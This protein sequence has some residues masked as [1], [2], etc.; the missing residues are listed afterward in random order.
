MDIG[1]SPPRVV[2]LSL[3]GL[4]L[5]G[6]I[7]P[8]LGELTRLTALR[9]DGNGLRGGVP[10][11]LGQLAHLELLWLKNNSLAGALPAALG[12]LPKLSAVRL[13]GNELDGPVPAPLF[14]LD[15]DLHETLF[16]L[17]S[18]ATDP[19]LLQDCNALLAGRDTLAGSARL[20][21]RRGLPIGLWQGVELGGAPPRVT[22]LDVAAL[23]LSGE[24]PPELGQLAQLRRL[25]LGGN[26]LTGTVPVALGRLA[27]LETLRLF[28]AADSSPGIAAGGATP[29]GGGRD[30]HGAA[31]TVTDFAR[32][33]PCAPDNP[34]LAA[35]CRVLLAMRDTLAGSGV[36]NWDLALPVERW[37]GVRLA[38]SP[39]RVAQLRLAA[40][41]LNGRVPA[42][43]AQLDQLETVSLRH[44][45]LTGGIP[46]ELGRLAKLKVLSLRDNQLTGPIPPALGRLHALERLLLNQNNLTGAIPQALA[47]LPRLTTIL[48]EKNALGGCAPP[49]GLL[50]VESHDL[51]PD[52]FHCL[53]LGAHKAGLAHDAAILLAARDQIAGEG[54]LNWSAAISV[55]DWQ[56]VTLAQE[57]ASGIV[58][59]DLRNA[60]LTGQ[61]PRQFGNLASLESL[62]LNGN[63][64]SGP[65]PPEIAQLANL[66]ELGLEDN[67]L[68]GVVP[69]ALGMRPGQL[70]AQLAGNQFTGPEPAAQPGA[71]HPAVPA[72][73]LCRPQAPIDTELVLDCRLLLAVRDALA[74][75]GT[76]NWLESMPLASWRGVRIAGDPAR[77]V[78][79]ELP[80]AGLAGQIPPRLAELPALR[81]LVL[82]GN[83]LTGP[84]P[85]ALADLTQLV[86]LNLEGNALTG[87]VPPALAAAADP[88]RRQPGRP[89]AANPGQ[90]ASAGRHRNAFAAPFPAALRTVADHDLPPECPT[91]R[92]ANPGLVQD[93]AHLL[94]SRDALAGT[95][96]LNWSERT[97][98]A[99]WQ[100]V[101][102][103]GRPLRVTAVEL[104]EARLTG[105]LPAA[106]GRLDRLER[107]QL[108]GN[109]L[110]GPIPPELGALTRLTHLA[111]AR[112]RLSGPIPRELG[113]LPR[114]AHLTLAGNDLDTSSADALRAVEHHDLDIEVFCPVARAQA[115]ALFDDCQTLLALRDPLAGRGVLNWRGAAP[116]GAWTGVRLGGDPLRVVALELAGTGIDGRIPAE[117]ANLGALQKLELSGNALRG[118][119]PAALARLPRLKTLRLADNRLSG[120]LP[121]AL[122]ALDLDVLRLAG[123]TFTRPLPAFP[124]GV[125]T[126]MAGAPRCAGLPPGNRGLADDCAE[127]LSLQDE[128]AGSAQLNW[129]AEAPIEGWDGVQ[130]GGIPR[131]VTGLSLGGEW[132]LDGRLPASLGRLPRLELIYLADNALTGPIPAE[133]GA[134][135][136]LK[137]LDIRLNQLSGAIPPELSRLGRLQEMYLSRNRLTGHVPATLAEMTDLA[138]FRLKGNLF[139]DCAAPEALASAV[140]DRDLDHDL[141]H[142]FLCLPM[143]RL[144][145]LARDAAALLQARDA[146]AGAGALDWRDDAPLPAWEGVTLSRGRHPR[147]Q[148]LDLSGKMLTGNIPASI[149]DLD[150]LRTLHLHGNALRGAVPQ[151]LGR[152]RH[153]ES[154]RLDGNRLDGTLPPALGGLKSLKLLRL[155]GNEFTGVAPVAL[156]Q[157]A[158][159]DL[160]LGP[161]CRPGTGGTTP[162]L[163]RDCA[164]LLAV[165]DALAGTVAL[166]WHPRAPIDFWRG[167]SLGGAPARVVAL[168]LTNLGLT[169]S[170]PPELGDLDALLALRL[171]RNALTGA[172]PGAL[173]GLA[174]LQELALGGNLLT[175]SIPPELGRLA[176][177]TTLRL[178]N[179]GLEG[180]IPAALGRLPRLRELALDGNALTGAMPP[181][182][183]ES[184]A[185]EELW[186][187]GNAL[188]GAGA[189]ATP[190]LARALWDDPPAP[191]PPARALRG[192]P[193]A[194]QVDAAG[195]PDALAQGDGTTPPEAPLF[196]TREGTG[197]PELLHDCKRLVLTLEDLTDPTAL[198]WRPD[199][200]LAQWQ[201]VRLGGEPLRVTGIDVSGMGVEGPLSGYFAELPA[202][203]TWRMADNALTGSIPPRIGR[204]SALRV[205]SLERNNLTGVLPTSFENLD[206]L[207][208]LRLND[209]ALTGH[210]VGKLA[211]LPNLSSMRLGGNDFLGC[212]PERL[213]GIGDRRLELDLDCGPTPWSKPGLVED[214]AALMASREGLA[215]GA[216]LNWLYDN[217]ISAWQGVTVDGSPPRVVALDLAFMGLAGHIPRELGSLTALARLDLTGNQLTGG[218]PAELGRL[219]KLHT[220][221]LTANRLSGELPEALDHLERI[222]K[223]GIH[224]NDIVG[225]PP[226]ML[227]W[228]ARSELLSLS[229]AHCPATWHYQTGG[230]MGG[231]LLSVNSMVDPG[232][233]MHLAQGA[234]NLFLQMGL[235]TGLLGVGALGL[236]CMSLVLNLRSRRGRAVTPV[237]ALA[238]AGV[239]MAIIHSAFDIFLLQYMMS[240]AV[241]VWMFLGLGTGLAQQR[242]EPD[243]DRAPDA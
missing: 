99:V 80:A 46:P 219:A 154:L 192:D 135:T 59:L 131:R 189:G 173:G 19:G 100:G 68:S 43:L 164:I 203:E 165:R 124:A 6:R 229:L 7:P 190:T 25:A 225:C 29:G 137:R 120:A 8:V 56:G 69:P 126:D 44:N 41:G 163:Q 221:L 123:N 198:N 95:A 210:L 204:L 81:R 89:P 24:I 205:L 45:A 37:E 52:I 239:A 48:L 226:V 101:A 116:L 132:G 111:L 232:R 71:A 96:V 218:V 169:G 208:E 194:P 27:E 215:G 181:G 73:A 168:D 122:A 146:L 207:A 140:A 84:I 172:I 171:G 178:R 5:N 110:A 64:L 139:L 142:T 18:A 75:G 155:A 212:M 133:L 220:L 234:H 50:D 98:M 34:G 183:G 170:I 138:K 237:Q 66:R 166:N 1:G 162:S 216:E 152:L 114:L 35:D 33:P 60:G 49:P 211:P 174:H 92:R 2:A 233:E 117:L 145:D 228:R 193:P 121:A 222:A 74:G 58:A 83:A 36:L 147:V 130:I 128:L 188:A 9:L 93:C 129:S 42:A 149:G 151:E 113:A 63:Q 196:C 160:G 53:P 180:R 224:G 85:A 106:L 230:W 148:G 238:A 11:E 16:C 40:Q 195:A 231:T 214:A 200:P 118:E 150:A 242:A 141:D 28:L 10:A 227:G 159:H 199:V 47:D 26:A 107:L 78:A 39:P 187:A 191:P 22:G 17:P 103:E 62:R 72:G 30:A 213:R 176:N 76:L 119:V 240:V 70:T 127:L 20:N 185:L 202:L 97:H 167:V 32:H 243:A 197:T 67:A 38:G 4:G 77:V 31:S 201:G 102:L 15:H 177:L 241:F 51:T 54:E 104:P 175:G 182:L 157:A 184:S 179:N 3:G 79:L 136:R 82:A 144:H 223:L 134:L 90:G 217:P 55:A 115:P 161:R 14:A 12:R 88:W 206:A 108:N 236:L 91:V 158:D 61:I 112:N 57:E 94:A 87:A 21:W 23:G 109:R 125:D 13:A 105:R 209:N 156:R 86:H 235:Q 153:L 65:I 143:E 186:L